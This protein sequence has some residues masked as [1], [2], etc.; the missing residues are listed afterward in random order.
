[1]ELYKRKFKEISTKKKQ[2]ITKKLKAQPE[3]EEE[4]IKATKK[5]KTQPKIEEEDIEKK[6]TLSCQIFQTLS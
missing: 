1:M 4:D 3:I 5:L 2:Q 6:T